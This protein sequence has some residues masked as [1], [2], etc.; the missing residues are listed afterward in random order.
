MERER[1]P[2]RSPEVTL[3]E[4]EVDEMLTTCREVTIVD[5]YKHLLHNPQ[6]LSPEGKEALGEYVAE[7]ENDHLEITGEE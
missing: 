5:V 1:R 7:H 3:T 2:E 4:N 6:W